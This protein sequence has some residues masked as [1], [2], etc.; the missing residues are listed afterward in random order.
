MTG[1]KKARLADATALPSSLG[2]AVIG[3]LDRSPVNPNHR[4]SRST[5]VQ[6]ID[7]CSASCGTPLSAR[8]QS[9]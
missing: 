6:R 7:A 1:K 4:N 9:R 8:V 3:F 5:L 2:R